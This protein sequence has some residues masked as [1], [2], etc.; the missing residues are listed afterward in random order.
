MNKLP[1]NKFQIGDLVS[2]RPPPA[3]EITAVTFERDN[4]G[5]VIPWYDV[6][7]E[8]GRKLTGL[9]E[10]GILGI[11]EV[12]TARQK[13][14]LDAVP[15]HDPLSVGVTAGIG[16]LPGDASFGKFGDPLPEDVQ[17]N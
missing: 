14:E 16:S 3:V 8:D 2:M 13:A 1:Q 10:H 17:A 12:A 6:I 15:K 5:N 9:P 4:T 7:T 11:D